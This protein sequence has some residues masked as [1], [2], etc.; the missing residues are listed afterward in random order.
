MFR[1]PEAR[2]NKQFAMMFGLNVEEI[3]Y[4]QPTTVAE[5]FDK[6]RKWEPEPEGI[7]HGV[8]ADSLAA[9]STEMEL[10]EKDGMGMRRAKE[11]SEEMRKS[12]RI[13]ANKGFLV[14]CSNQLR[15]R[16][17]APAFSDPYKT[18]GG[19]AIGFYS[20][21][22]LRCKKPEE[23]K[24]KIMIAK[25]EVV[26]TIGVNTSIKVTKSSIWEPFHSADLII[27]FDYGIDDIRANL[28]FI[29]QMTGSEKYGLLKKQLADSIDKA[30]KVVEH[31]G[32]EQQ[33]REDTIDL[34]EEIEKKFKQ[35]RKPKERL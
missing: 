28:F 6:I 15:Q 21:L 14:V 4:D 16:A 30:C 23:I 17:N 22:R 19:E 29:K 33:L 3:D 32:L 25:K 1:D 34:W 12:C 13:I 26:R 8:F 7:T 2:L 24:K 9:L 10:E 31:D 35:V 11:F 20:S 27:M 5:V 18:P